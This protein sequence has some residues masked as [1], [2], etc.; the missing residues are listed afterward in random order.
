MGKAICSGV[1]SVITE[2][3]INEES[4]KEDLIP[5]KKDEDINGDK[6]GNLHDDGKQET[7]NQLSQDWTITKVHSSDQILEDIKRGVSIMIL[8]TFVSTMILFLILNLNRYM[9]LY[10]TGDC[11]LLCK[12]NLSNLNVTMFGTL[13]YVQL[14]KPPLALDGYLGSIWMK[15]V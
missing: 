6:D 1:S 11:Y 12:K 7:S 5:S 2:N 15:M 13:F 10:L 9:M 8:I 4:F 3:L 14:I